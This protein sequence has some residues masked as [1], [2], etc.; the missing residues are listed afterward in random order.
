MNRLSEFKNAPVNQIITD[1]FPVM[2]YPS[3]KAPDVNLQN[4]RFSVYGLVEKEIRWSWDE[5]M[6]FPQVLTT[7]DFHCVTQWSKFDNLWE[8]IQFSSI[9]SQLKLLPDAKYVM[10]HSYGGYSTNLDLETLLDDDVILAHHHNS[11][12][13]S[14]DHGGP[15]RLVVPKR[16]AWK[17]AKWIK[18]LEFKSS[19]QPGFWESRGY[20]MRGNPWLEERYWPELQR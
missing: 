8:G 18:S 7:S 13:L 10:V 2:T 15:L 6:D 16:Y 9:V 20:H 19:E 1:K 12:P 3:G 5:L 14:L 17:S 11:A 4:W